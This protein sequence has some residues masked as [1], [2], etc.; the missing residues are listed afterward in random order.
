MSALWHHAKVGTAQAIASA[1]EVME[2]SVHCLRSRLN[3]FRSRPALSLLVLS[4]KA[5]ACTKCNTRIHKPGY[6]GRLDI[7]CYQATDYHAAQPMYHASF[8]CT[9]RQASLQTGNSCLLF[10]QL[11]CCECRHQLYQSPYNQTGPGCPSHERPNVFCCF[12][13]M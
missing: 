2:M 11:S 10:H 4:D 1:H 13:C 3:V 12:G 9:P 5:N 7:N 8:L 6:I